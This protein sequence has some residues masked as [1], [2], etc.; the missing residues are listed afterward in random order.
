MPNQLS[1]LDKTVIVNNIVSQI[2][3]FYNSETKIKWVENPYI[4]IYTRKSIRLFNKEK[5][6][7]LDIA[8]IEVP[9]DFRGQGIFEQTLDRIILEFPETNLF[10]ES[11]LNIKLIP[12]LTRKGFISDDSKFDENMFLIR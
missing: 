8:N 9:E 2:I 10:V 7:C 11:I 3:D 5:I 1:D 6:D 4:K 12:F